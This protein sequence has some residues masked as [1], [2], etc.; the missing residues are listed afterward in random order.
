M[1]GAQCPQVVIRSLNAAAN[2]LD[3]GRRLRQDG[4]TVPRRVPDRFALFDLAIAEL[5]DAKA[6]YLEFGVFRGE[7][8]RYWSSG[9]RHPEAQLHGFDSFL[10]LPEDW[11]SGERQGHFSTEGVPPHIDDPRVSLFPGW[12]EDTLS[13][14]T[15]PPHDALFVNV[16]SDLYA[17][18]KT[19]LTNVGPLMVPGTFLYFDEF[20]DRLHEGRAFFEYVRSS[21]ARFEVVA[22]SPSLTHVLFRRVD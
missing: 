1:L 13:Q 14:Y 6:L 2:Y 20:F 11:T 15:A 5:R 7:T 16:D 8:L 19:V 9:L 12:F 22:G 17:S 21:G 10:G 3:T 4:L 18:A